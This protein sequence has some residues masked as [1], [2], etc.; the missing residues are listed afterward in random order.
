MLVAG[1]PTDSSKMS[2][3]NRAHHTGRSQH[4]E[5]GPGGSFRRA[6]PSV[7][8]QRSGSRAW[9]RRGLAA[10]LSRS[11]LTDRFRMTPALAPS[12]GLCVRAVGGEEDPYCFVGTVVWF[13]AGEVFAGAA[14]HSLVDRD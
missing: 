6:L 8:P 1:C 13:G 14:E 4:K 5:T 2:V 11:R 3:P 9:G 10:S 12:G 7:V